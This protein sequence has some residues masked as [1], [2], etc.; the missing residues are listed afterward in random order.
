MRITSE[1]D[2]CVG[3][4]MCA[5]T[6][7]EIFDQDEDE[8]MVIVLDPEPAPEQEAAV[9]RVVGMCPSGAIRVE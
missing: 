2:V 5:L 6:L 3:A 8:G 7:P 4:G 9:R 1:P